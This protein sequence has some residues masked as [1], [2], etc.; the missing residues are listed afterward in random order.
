MEFL[1][2]DCLCH[3]R[4]V[5]GF[6]ICFTDQ[7]G[8]IR[9]SSTGTYMEINKTRDAIPMKQGVHTSSRKLWHTI[10][11]CLALFFISIISFFSCACRPCLSRSISLIDLSSILLFSRRSSEEKKIWNHAY[12]SLQMIYQLK[13]KLIITTNTMHCSQ[14][15]L[16]T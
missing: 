14:L 11:P 7:S 13:L 8:K 1:H 3:S 6:L 12:L 16:G 2:W 5:F 9:S 15:Y 4:A 10:C